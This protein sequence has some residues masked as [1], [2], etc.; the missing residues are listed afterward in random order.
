[1]KEMGGHGVLAC[2][3]QE[4]AADVKT[5]KAS[6]R[7]KNVKSFLEEPFSV[8]GAGGLMRPNTI[9]YGKGWVL[10]LHV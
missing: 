7:R 8:T 4:A 9:I 6:W 5:S 2:F 10:T 3:L 1:M